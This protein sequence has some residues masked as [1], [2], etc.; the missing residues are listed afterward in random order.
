MTAFGF[1]DKSIL[2]SKTLVTRHNRF[3]EGRRKEDVD[4]AA[5][6]TRWFF[7]FVL[8]LAPKSSPSE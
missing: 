6:V 2:S 4:T 1:A 8:P 3:S 5:Q 7:A